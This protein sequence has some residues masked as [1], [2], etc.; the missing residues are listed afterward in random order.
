[1][2][3]LAILFLP[4]YYYEVKKKV[5]RY[6]EK[7]MGR[8]HIPYETEAQKELRKLNNLAKAQLDEHMDHDR[9]CKVKYQREYT[10][11][12][13]AMDLLKYFVFSLYPPWI[14]KRIEVNRIMHQ[15]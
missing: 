1:M 12:E 7:Q 8:L 3:V 10:P 9:F 11:V 15:M 6:Y 5:V 4:F 2:Y 14:E 13:T